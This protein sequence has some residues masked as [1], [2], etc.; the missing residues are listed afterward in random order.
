VW[1]VKLYKPGSLEEAFQNEEQTAY[2]ILHLHRQGNSIIQDRSILTTLTYS[3]LENNADVGRLIGHIANLAVLPRFIFYLDYPPN[4]AWQRKNDM[5]NPEFIEKVYNTYD[6]AIELVTLNF[7]TT[8]IRI[9]ATKQLE[10]KVQEVMN[11][12]S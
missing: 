11:A 6:K 4:L 12:I 10:Q 9:D 5:Y 1:Q 7:A 8:I 2:N 3:L